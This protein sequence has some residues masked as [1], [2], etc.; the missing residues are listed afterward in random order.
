MRLIVTL[1]A[2]VALTGCEQ[3]VPNNTAE[4]ST[5]AK[6]SAASKRAIT[7]SFDCDRASGQAQEMICG[8]SALAAMDRE[9]A[10]LTALAAE[11]ASQAEWVQQRDSCAKADELRQCVMAAAM[12]KIHR[13]RQGSAAA[14]AGDEASAGPV[15][16]ACRGITGPL[17]VT[18]VKHDPG[19]MV[20]EWDGQAIAI[21]QVVAA[22]G[23]RYEGRWNG[24]PYGFWDN[25]GEAI[26]TLPGRGDVQCHEARDAG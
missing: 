12:L 11:P 10:R 26:L 4:P 7:A 25:G 22:S 18:F 16:F 14:R 21:D 13:L 1:A 9:V 6:P 15:E 5:T 23:A 3:P 8:D 2:S 19:A 24:Q 20:L 17:A